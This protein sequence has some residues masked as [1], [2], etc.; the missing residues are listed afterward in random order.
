MIK[1]ILY[2]LIL[3]FCCQAQAGVPSVVV[4]IQP[5]Q[6][7][8]AGVMEGVGVPKL[9]LSPHEDAHHFSLTPTEAR[10]INKANLFIWVG[11]Q[12][13]M[14]L[15][16]AV[17]TLAVNGRV[18]K[19]IDTPGLT[20]YELNGGQVDPHI[21][22]DPANAKVIVQYVAQALSAVDPDHAGVYGT[23][24]EK[25]Q[26]QLDEL[27]AK[28]L[29]ELEPI[30]D[31]Q[32]FVYHD[33]FQYYE[34][35]FGLTRSIPLVKDSEHTIRASQMQSIEKIASEGKIHCVFGEP[36]HGEKVVESVA[37]ELDL[38]MGFLDPISS[39]DNSSAAGPYFDMMEQIASSLK[40]CLS[41]GPK[42]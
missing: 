40:G 27:S 42:T 36:N 12:M 18:L 34:K 10:S 37:E 20:K 39:R 1:R 11:P 25:L 23:N 33:A 5:I 22:L 19:L 15:Q 21:W 16:N 14:A 29:K 7:L 30:K 9:L 8:V 41:R 26:V 28:L 32:Y 24:A 4:S 3:C 38:E 31:K 6:A 2:T 17:R 35:A 13:E